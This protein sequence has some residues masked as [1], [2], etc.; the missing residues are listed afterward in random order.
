MIERIIL[1]GEKN[2]SSDG[3]ILV[4]IG[5]GQSLKLLHKVEEGKK[6]RVVQSVE[7]YTG[8]VRVLCMMK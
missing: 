7:D 3:W 5:K 1:E 6:F 8:A 4:E 2:I